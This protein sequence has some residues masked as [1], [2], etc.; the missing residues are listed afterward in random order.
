MNALALAFDLKS[1]AV[2]LVKIRRAAR[3]TRAERIH[4]LAYWQLVDSRRTEQFRAAPVVPQL[5]SAPTFKLLLGLLR[6]FYCANNKSRAISQPLS[7][8]SLGARVYVTFRYAG[9]IRS[10]PTAHCGTD[11]VPLACVPAALSQQRR[12]N[13]LTSTFLFLAHRSPRHTV[14][15][16]F[17]RVASL[18]SP[19]NFLR[20]S[21]IV[22][23]GRK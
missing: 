7:L 6:T 2:Q 1:F 20:L 4:R 16:L 9:K 18:E 12:R 21:S 23:S 10:L 19:T 3:V 11:R 15:Y 13:R 17:L 22:R 14:P 5:N 8:L